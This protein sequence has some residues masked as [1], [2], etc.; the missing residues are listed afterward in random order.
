MV[1]QEPMT[2]LDPVLPIGLQITESLAAHLRLHGRAAQLRAIELLDL[3]GI[4][5]ATRRLRLVPA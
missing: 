2:A 3:V 1:F 5:D 4:P